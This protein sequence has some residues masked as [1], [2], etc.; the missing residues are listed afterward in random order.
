MAKR[1]ALIH[2]TRA[3]IA[4]VET[5][6]AEVWPEARF[7]NLLDES[8]AQEIDAA[9][10]LTAALTKRFIGLGTYAKD[11]GVDGILFTCSAFGPA[12]EA[13]ARRFD[14]PALKP[15]EALLET[16]IDGGGTVGL[17]AT[18]PP[19]LPNMTRQFEDL[20]RQ[21][22]RDVTVRPMLADGAWAHLGNG[23]QAAHDAAVIKAA[24]ALAECDAIALAQFSMAPLTATI[25][26]AVPCPVLTSPH[27]AV[28]AMK[29]RVE[30]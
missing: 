18:H 20:A 29:A 16:A 4:P 11:T 30:G 3:S 14:I 8:L 1:I 23:D 6:F 12:I 15:N 25:Q 2:A 19:T 10:E 28:A 21:R 17:L 27:T 5:A 7:W 13:C 26:T 24:K 22:G 9:G